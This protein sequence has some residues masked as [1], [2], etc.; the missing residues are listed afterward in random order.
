MALGTVKPLLA[1]WCADGD[2]GVQNVLALWGT[3]RDLQVSIHAYED[4]VRRS[5]HILR[6]HRR[7]R[8]ACARVESKVG[9]AALYKSKVNFGGRGELS[10][11]F[12]NSST[13]NLSAVS[14]FSVVSLLCVVCLGNARCTARRTAI[15]LHEPNYEMPPI[16]NRPLVPSFPLHPARL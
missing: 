7:R 3:R 16:L 2:L 8:C 10:R 9:G 5:H 15:Q 6:A 14:W 1:T 4:T 13:D 11:D 12:R